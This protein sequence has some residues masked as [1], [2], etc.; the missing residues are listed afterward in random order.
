MFRSELLL[1][2]FLGILV[3]WKESQPIYLHYSLYINS[4][5]ISLSGQILFHTLGHRGNA[6]RTPSTGIYLVGDVVF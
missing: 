1:R 2:V 4:P 3:D 6:V 5:S